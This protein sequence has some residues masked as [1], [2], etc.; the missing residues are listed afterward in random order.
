M[1]LDFLDAVLGA[2]KK[3]SLEGPHGKSSLTFAVP[4]GVRDGEKIRLR[5]K[6][7]PGPGGKAGDLI[8]KIRVKPHERFRRDGDHIT[9]SVGVSFAEAVLGAKVE[10]LTPHGTTTVSIPPGTQGGQVLR[11]PGEGVRRK[12][13]PPGDVL[14]TVKILV[15]K[16]VDEKSRE[17]IRRF[18]RANPV[19]GQA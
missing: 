15:P 13:A 12:G 2:T 16:N 18:D 14:V 1:D 3:I 17:L 6:G 9:T 7:M 11:L 10:I 8:I 19:K 5:G 4:P